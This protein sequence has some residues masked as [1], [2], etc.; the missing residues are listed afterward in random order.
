MTRWK[1]F[2]G[3]LVDLV[4]AGWSVPDNL[5]HPIQVIGIG[6]HLTFTVD[7][8]EEV[9]GLRSILAIASSEPLFLGE[10]PFQ[11][12]GQT[13]A[14]Q[15]HPASS[16]SLSV[17][18]VT[19]RSVDELG[20]VW[21]QVLVDRLQA[22]LDA[23]LGPVSDVLLGQLSGEVGGWVLLRNLIGP[24]IFRLR[25]RIRANQVV[26]VSVQVAHASAP[27]SRLM[28]SKER[29]III[30]SVQRVNSTD[31]R[32]KVGTAKTRL[33]V[34]RMIIANRSASL[35]ADHFVSRSRGQ[36]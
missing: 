7:D 35:A 1:R 34:S 3:N 2:R 24:S 5:G 26:P 13:I 20:D 14:S 29:W 17:G 15:S 25:S 11:L 10:Q 32:W 18:I 8:S 16:D 6:Q 28:F 27:G 30:G 19:N 9:H 36:S 12:F 22:D 21:V 33:L 23:F 4:A 31:D